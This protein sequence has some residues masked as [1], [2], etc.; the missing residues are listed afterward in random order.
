AWEAGG[1]RGLVLGR[2][3]FMPS[4]AVGIHAEAVAAFAPNPRVYR[5]LDVEPAPPRESF[6]EKRA[7]LDSMLESARRRGWVV[8]IF[9]PAALRGPAGQGSVMLDDL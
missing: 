9:E 6:P 5:A 4:P 3:V 8:L 7:Q 2:A 1:V